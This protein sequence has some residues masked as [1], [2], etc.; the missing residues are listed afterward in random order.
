MRRTAS[1]LPAAHAAAEVWARMSARLER[2]H[3]ARPRPFWTGARVAL[4]M[5]ATL[6]VAVT[7]SLWLLRSPAPPPAAQASAAPAGRRRPE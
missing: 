3:A 6:V 7:A 1:E 4:A 5:A 2:E